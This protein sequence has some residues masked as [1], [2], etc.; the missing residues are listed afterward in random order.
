MIMR[1]PLAVPLFCENLRKLLTGG[2]LGEHEP[3]WPKLDLGRWSLL[4]IGTALCRHD[5]RRDPRTRIQCP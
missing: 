5:L 1:W 2:Y 3:P 4:L